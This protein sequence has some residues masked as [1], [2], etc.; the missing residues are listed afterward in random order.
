M[1]LTLED[2]QRALGIGYTVYE[3]NGMMYWRIKIEENNDENKSM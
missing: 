2:A 3:V 1:S